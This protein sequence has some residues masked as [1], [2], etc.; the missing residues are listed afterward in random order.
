[1][2]V[3][4]ATMAGWNIMQQE[5]MGRTGIAHC[6]GKISMRRVHLNWMI[7]FIIGVPGV[8]KDIL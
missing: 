4:T 7:H 2:Y 1:M 5:N 3:R 6:V 8:T